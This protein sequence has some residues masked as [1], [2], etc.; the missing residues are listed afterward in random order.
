MRRDNRTLERYQLA[1]EKLIDYLLHDR[2]ASITDLNI[3]AGEDPVVVR[4]TVLPLVRALREHT[5]LGI[6][7]CLGT[8][9]ER[10]YA[11]LRESG[12]DYYVIKIETGDPVHYGRLQS[13]GNLSERL[14]AIRH[15]AATGWEV[16]SGF[17]AGLPGQTT[18]E[19]LDTLGMLRE[20]PLA[21]CSVSPFVPGPQTPLAEEPAGS[22]D[23][24][25]NCLALMRID[26]PRRIIPAVSAMALRAED[27]YVRAL[28]A[29]ANLATINCTPVD[30]RGDYVLY[31]TDR[32]IMTEELILT[33][34]ERAG[35]TPSRVGVSE[36]LGRRRSTGC[37][38]TAR[39]GD[40]K[41][42]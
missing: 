9:P 25:L 2:P 15:L 24:T 21:G 6:S 3:Q 30:V 14:A 34:I 22:L 28:R 37:G 5:G 16:S 18:A 41:R 27:G 4:E 40:L 35:C 20:L 12:A 31:Q 26:S 29:G 39:A 10:V 8:L 42:S 1:A 19:I 17:I 7:V 36:T 33:Q 11:E 38:F 23:L 13:P 32:V